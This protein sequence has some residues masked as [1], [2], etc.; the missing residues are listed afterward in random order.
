M[1]ADL[2]DLFNEAVE[3][4][5]AE[6]RAAFLEKVCG[7]DGELR[8][9]M[10]DLL[11][12]HVEMGTEG[13]FLGGGGDSAAGSGLTKEWA[14]D[15]DGQ[16]GRYKLLQK[17]GE[18]G[19]GIVYMAE[20]TEPVRRRVALK[21]LKPGMDSRQVMARF[22]AERQALAMMSH[23]NIAGVLDAGATEA[24]RPY[25]VMELVRGIR[26]TDYCDK[27]RLTTTE[28]LELFAVVCQA[29]Q[30]AH[31]KGIIHRDIKPS[32]VL[33]TSDGGKPVPRIID[34]GV[35]KATADVRLTDKT[36]FTR[37]EM[38]VGT[39]A[40]MSPEQAEFS[41]Q[42]VDTRT[43]IYALGVL[44]YELLTGQTPF[45]SQTLISSGV[46]A[47]RRTIREQ[48][49]Q[50]PST[51]LR[52][53]APQTVETVAAQ[54]Q[55]DM[56]RLI[57]QVKGDLDWIVLKALEKDRTRRYETANGLGMD[58]QRF[59]NDEPIAARPPSAAYTLRKWARR[60]RAAF[61]GSTA[62]LS[63]LLLGA[64]ASTWQAV[65]ATRAE[66]EQ[67][68]LRAKSDADRAAADAA[69]NEALI[70]AYAADMKA[71][72]V[73][74][75][76]GNL[77][78]ANALL[79]RHVP[80]D[81]RPD[82][83][84]FEWGILRSRAAGDETASFDHTGINAGIAL[85]P[86]NSWGAA[87][88]K[89]GGVRVWE[90]ATGKLL[91]QFP[92]LKGRE[93]RRSIAL[94]PDGTMLAY[95]SDDS[96]WVRGT[97][98][99]EVLREIPVTANALAFS[100]GGLL[101]WGANDSLRF[102]NAKTFAEEFILKDAAGDPA[103]AGT[104]STSKLTFA[105]DGSR[106]CVLAAGGVAQVWDVAERRILQRIATD[107]YSSA[108]ISPDGKTVAVGTYPG[109]IIL[110]DPLTGRELTRT[111]AHAPL[112]LD[113][114]F[115]PDSKR[116]VS[117]G[118]DQSMRSWDLSSAET[119][120]SESGNWRGHWNEV[121]SVEFS[122][123]GKQL[124]TGGKDAKVKLWSA[125]PSSQRVT[126]LNIA[127]EVTGFFAAGDRFRIKLQDRILFRRVEDGAPAGE[128]IIPPEYPQ[129]HEFCSGD[130]VFLCTGDGR[131]VM[132]ELPGGELK[133]SIECR[134]K[135]AAAVA[136]LSSDGGMLAL[137][138]QGNV[139][140][141]LWDFTTGTHLCELPDYLHDPT[142]PVYRR[143]SFSPDGQRVAYMASD[144]RVNIYDIPRRALV[145]ELTGFAWHLFCAAW[146][147]DG[148][149]LVTAG[150]DGDV[151]VWNPDTGERALPA[152]RGH[153]AGVPALTFS[154]DSRTLVTHGAERT[155]RFWNLPTGTEVLTLHDAVAPWNCPIS[156]DGRTM[157]WRRVD[158]A[159]QVERAR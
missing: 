147:P 142:T 69:R 6:Q 29:V 108:A 117:A 42:G 158:S 5:D 95:L 84:G 57:T 101:V 96:I 20:Q 126:E 99:W 156:P 24:G 59:L 26:I 104:D 114:T 93:P 33:V 61:I 145:H 50:K 35:A 77:G 112:V 12:V 146:S 122:R 109:W 62:V 54:R 25:F 75:E 125:K 134:D 150:W 10:D 85:A 88:A 1:S 135:P 119:L 56:H 141:D 8:R 76:E 130:N 149:W 23:P 107:R 60:H 55:S 45:D 97:E 133:R 36:L 71:V 82:V 143:L 63:A 159:I 53:L 64:I 67:R 72:S 138:R 34:F 39:P 13:G 19:W 49:P 100:P 80:Q 79:D 116:L 15:I 74:I 155:V 151:I 7:K 16:V 21:I 44:L 152:L 110:L 120:V 144:R 91:R 41:A 102:L 124:V 37:F 136:G 18:G 89:F 47:M 43:D 40:Y 92:A 58:V 131:T 78:Q 3:I 70:R 68:N 132:H 118:G 28:R 73:A 38:F 52:Q 46:D 105:A 94:S 98:K 32:N 66:H 22:E 81:G 86:D 121:W 157:V 128:W 51:K 4:G 111:Q 2:M 123:D 153:F 140:M 27:N 11:A 65:R 90:T 129:Q 139:V 9:K 148:R 154:A 113:L 83:R 127:G 48:D 137:L 30:H 115:S 14:G 103:N 31:Q 17:I 106:L 87:G